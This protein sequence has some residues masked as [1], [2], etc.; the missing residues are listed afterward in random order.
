MQTLSIQLCELRPI[1]I[2]TQVLYTIYSV[3]YSNILVKVKLQ[4]EQ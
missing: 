3:Q 1:K 2:V 4:Y